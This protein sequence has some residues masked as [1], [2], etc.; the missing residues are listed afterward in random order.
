[1][2]LRTTGIARPARAVMR[3]RW[4]S[5]SRATPLTVDFSTARRR[6]VESASV[7]MRG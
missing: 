6:N 1:L 7:L 4:P 2:R 3:Q 5:A